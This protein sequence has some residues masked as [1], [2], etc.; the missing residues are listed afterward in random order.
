MICCECNK[1][2]QESWNDGQNDYCTEC[3]DELVS[4]KMESNYDLD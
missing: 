3:R 1:E 2:I 4:S